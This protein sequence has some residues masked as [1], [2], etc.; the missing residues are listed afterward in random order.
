MDGVK[1]EI[2]FNREYTYSFLIKF[3]SF[4]DYLKWERK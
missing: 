4:G 2:M 1:T 3:V